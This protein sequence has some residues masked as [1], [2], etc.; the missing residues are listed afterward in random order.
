MGTLWH[1][2]ALA[3]FSVTVVL[4]APKRASASVVFFDWTPNMDVTGLPSSVYTCLVGLLMTQ[5]TLSG[6]DGCAHFAEETH[7]AVSNGCLLACLPA[8]MTAGD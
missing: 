4:V 7:S 3:A 1:I 8:G 6:Y 2:V 5:W